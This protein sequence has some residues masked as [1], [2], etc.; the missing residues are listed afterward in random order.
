MT[1]QFHPALVNPPWGD[2]AVYVDFLHERRAILFDLGDITALPTRKILRV[3][4]IFVSHA[5]VDHFIGFD[6]LVRICLGRRKTVHIYGP[7]GFTRRVEFR[8]AGYTWNLVENYPY[9]FTVVAVEVHPDGA[10]LS[11][12][13][14]CRN[15]FQREEE[16]EFS[17]RDNILLEEDTFRIRAVFLDHRIPSM[18]FSLEEKNHVNIMKNRIE[19]M[20]LRVGPWLAGLKGAVIRDEP[21]SAG[22]RAWWKEGGRVVEREVAL[23]ELKEKALRVVRG[24]KIV[25]VTDAAPTRENGGKIVELARDADYLFIETVFLDAE[26]ERAMERRHLTARRAGL[27]AREAGAARVVPFHFSPKYKGM[28]EKL[29]EELERASKGHAG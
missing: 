1:P 5:H 4:H 11:A 12:L 28:E 2:P 3:S 17:I 26:A 10:A 13:F 20:G 18:A 6:H 25:Y 15:R 19:D 14:R 22:F 16:K 29:R 24:Q 27:L 8:L 9:D 7:P 21:E 23:G